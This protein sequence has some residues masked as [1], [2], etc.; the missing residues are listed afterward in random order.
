MF[1][2]AA[3]AYAQD[4]YLGSRHS[5]PLHFNP[6]FAGNEYDTRAILNY[7]NHYP[8]SGTSFMTYSA[9][10]DTYL[11]SY[12]SGV[13]I[14]IMTDQLGSKVYSYNAAGLFYSYKIT[15]GKTSSVKLGLMSNLF[16]GVNDPNGLKF[17]DMINP[18]GSTSPNMFAYDKQTSFGVDFGFGALYN[19]EFFELGGALYH[20]GSP[21][22]YTYWNRP[23]R[24]YAHAEW[25]IPIFGGTVYSPRMGLSHYLSNS[26]LSPSVYFMHQGKITL[27]GVGALYNFMNFNIGLYSR[28]NLKMDS[29]TGS[30]HFGYI[31]DVL[32]AHYI[33]DMGFSGSNFRGLT[34]SSHEIGLVFKFS[35][36]KE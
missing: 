12:N 25:R 36:G 35:T 7:R 31:S 20:I 15:T 4:P 10:F 23:M 2:C 11:D 33:F 21:N 24:A 29:F 13:G 5:M 18:D 32:E 6:A 16:Y 30:F 28:Q 34:T 9:T 27:Y 1:S 14:S 22:K 19:T 3:T 8:T 17:P 26:T